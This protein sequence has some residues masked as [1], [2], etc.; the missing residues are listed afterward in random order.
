MNEGIAKRFEESISRY[1]E[2]PGKADKVEY[3]WWHGEEFAIV[4]KKVLEI[5]EENC[6]VRVYQGMKEDGHTPELWFRVYDYGV[7][8]GDDPVIW[9]YNLSH[10]CPPNCGGG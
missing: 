2:N 7:K 10:P 6:R 4:A 8:D 9:T 3:Q 1:Q 5:G